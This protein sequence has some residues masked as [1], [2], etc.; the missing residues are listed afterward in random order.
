MGI[1]RFSRERALQVLF[2]DDISCYDRAINLRLFSKAFPSEKN[3]EFFTRLVTGVWRYR[4]EIDII[5]KE[6]SNNWKIH[7]ISYV[8]RNIL[9]IAVFEMIYC[10]DIPSRVS[11]NEAVDLGKRF[12]TEESGAFINGILDSIYLEILDN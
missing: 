7:R 5:I 12:G 10:K 4:C 6:H 8:D 2:Y 9:R 11:I 3:T 1:R